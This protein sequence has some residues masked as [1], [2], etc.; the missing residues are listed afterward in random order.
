MDKLF[1]LLLQPFKNILEKAKDYN[2]FLGF[3]VLILVA[4]LEVL[5]IISIVSVGIIC[6]LFLLCIFGPFLFVFIYLA[7]FIYEYDKLYTNKKA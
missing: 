2:K 4:F 7:I 3:I 6:L 5:I 1:E